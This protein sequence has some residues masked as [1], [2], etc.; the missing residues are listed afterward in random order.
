MQGVKKPHGT[1]RRGQMLQIAS[2]GELPL[3]DHAAEAERSTR[4]LHDG[5]AGHALAPHENGDSDH[6]LVA[7]QRDLA[8]RTIRQVIDQGDDAG[9]REVQEVHM[10]PGFRHGRPKR[11]GDEFEIGE[12]PLVVC[13]GQCRE[14]LVFSGCGRR[15]RLRCRHGHSLKVGRPTIVAVAHAFRM[16][17]TS[18]SGR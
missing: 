11:Q 7:H 8:G 10:V 9:Y 1:V 2:Q 13:C 12:Y 18:L 14:Y 3:H 17:A 5:A 15:A 4:A 6:A 16:Y